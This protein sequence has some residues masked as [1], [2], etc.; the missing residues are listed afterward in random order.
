MQRAFS[1]LAFTLGAAKLD[2]DY[3]R[4]PHTLRQLESVF[5]T[6]DKLRGVTFYPTYMNEST[7]VHNKI[8][9]IL[10]LIHFQF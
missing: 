1:L 2:P 7:G 8:P 6:T 9:S 5:A 3:N 4:Y 10:G